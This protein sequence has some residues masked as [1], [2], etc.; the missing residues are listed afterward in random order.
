MRPSPKYLRPANLAMAL[1]F[2]FCMA[3]Q[4]NDPDPLHWIGLYGLAGLSCCLSYLGRLPRPLPLAL[5]FLSSAWAGLISV[6]VFGK[7]PASDLFGSFGMVNLAV[8]EA[9]EMIGLILIG[10]WMVVL[11][12][13]P[14]RTG[15]TPSD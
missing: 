9:R 6:R 11:I 1:L 13:F 12:L 14:S 2:L 3:L 15:S 7:G 5:G 8:E 4:V 10:L